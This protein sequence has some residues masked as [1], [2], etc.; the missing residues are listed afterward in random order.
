MWP[1]GAFWLW[2]N[3]G[4]TRIDVPVIRGLTLRT[5]GK[6]F[7]EVL[8]L[9]LCKLFQPKATT[10]DTR[11]FLTSQSGPQ[12]SECQGLTEMLAI[13]AC[14][15]HATLRQQ[16]WLS[17]HGNRS[18]LLFEAHTHVGALYISCSVLQECTRSISLALVSKYN[19]MADLLTQT[20]EHNDTVASSFP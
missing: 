10:L 7:S 16:G 18:N 11:V 13:A 17:S 20:Q 9:H 4:S 5:K 12:G 2:G 8:A 19:K 3:I 14:L 6:Q 15:P 1:L